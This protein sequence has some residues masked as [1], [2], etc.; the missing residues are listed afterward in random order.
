MTVRLC[1]DGPWFVTWKVY[2]PG[3]SFEPPVTV[4][5]K[6]LSVTSTVEPPLGWLEAAAAGVEAA[7]EAGEELALEPPLEL[8]PQ[9][10]APRASAPARTTYAMGLVRTSR[11]IPS[12]YAPLAD[13]PTCTRAELKAATDAYVE[14]QRRGDLSALPH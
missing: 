11:F 10:A 3:A 9:A 12:P 2:V 6:S 4:I 5:E 1:A 8:L 13:K 7:V 14:A